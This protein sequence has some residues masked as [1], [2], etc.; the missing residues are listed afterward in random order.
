MKFM[1]TILKMKQ[2]KNTGENLFEDM[3][4]QNI[5]WKE[6]ECNERFFTTFKKRK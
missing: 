2:N 3:E 4:I 5:N 6:E 1:M